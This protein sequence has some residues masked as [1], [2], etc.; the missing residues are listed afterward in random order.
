MRPGGVSHSYTGT[1][2]ARGCACLPS[3][4]GLSGHNNNYLINHMILWHLKPIKS[5]EAACTCVHCSQWRGGLSVT[6]GAITQ[7]AAP[8]PPPP[9]THTQTHMLPL[10]QNFLSRYRG[11]CRISARRRWVPHECLT[12]ERGAREARENF[13]S[14]RS[15]YCIGN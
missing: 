3:G 5:V 2:Y 12:K 9:P 4:A 10:C 11:G 1:L 13:C 8:P 15:N 14:A 6:G 7:T